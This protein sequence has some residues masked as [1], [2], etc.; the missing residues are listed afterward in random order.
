MPR[1]TVNIRVK[2]PHEIRLSEDGIRK[3]RRG[4]IL[5]LA[6]SFVKTTEDI[7]K[8]STYVKRALVL[9]GEKYS[10]WDLEVELVCPLKEVLLL[11]E[12]ELFFSP[13][14]REIFRERSIL[15]PGKEGSGKQVF[16][17][18]RMVLFEDR[19][20]VVDFKSEVPASAS[21]HDE[22]RNQVKNYVQLAQSL[23]GLPAEGYLLFIAG[24]K[25]KKV[26]GS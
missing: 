18:D 14:A 11:P 16:R 19:V 2:G 7:P 17:P 5:H 24:P 4:E 13:K 6:L 8:L 9:L 20:V 12:A 22:Y 23:F 15:L 21:L 3:R 25:V 10:S 1:A 26:Y